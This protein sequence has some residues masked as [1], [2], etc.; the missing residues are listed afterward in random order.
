MRGL[1]VTKKR[2]AICLMSS[3]SF[4]LICHGF[5]M[6]NPSYSHDS[7]TDFVR[8]YDN[9]QVGL[10]RFGQ[11]AWRNLFGRVTATWWIG[12]V[13]A[14]CFGL[15]A[16]LISEVFNTNKTITNILMT[17][18]LVTN[19][20]FSNSVATYM[21][22]VDIYGGALLFSVISVYFAVRYKY[23]FLL[24]FPFVSL[25]LSLYQPYALCVPS[26]LI[27]FVLTRANE[28]KNAIRLLTKSA[29]MLILGY[30]TYRFVLQLYLD[31]T[32]LNLSVGYNSISNIG[33]PMSIL[34]QPWNEIA[35][36]YETG[37][38]FA[39]ATFKDMP[40]F[41]LWIAIFAISFVTEAA[42]YQ[43][44]ILH[45]SNYGKTAFYIL[46][47]LTPL[48]FNFQYIVSKAV[49]HVLMVYSVYFIWLLPL[50]FFDKT[51][52]NVTSYNYGNNKYIRLLYKGLRFLTP[53]V[54]VIYIFANTRYANN[55]YTGK[56]LRERSTLSVM[57]RIMSRAE[58]TQ[59]YDPEKMPI[60]LVGNLENNP[61]IGESDDAYYG[62]IV[63]DPSRFISI[64]N[65]YNAYLHYYMGY[66]YSSLRSSEI[67]Q[68]NEEVESMPAYPNEG[69]TKVID[70]KLVIK[71]AQN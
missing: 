66:T 59:G 45:L 63:G 7:L 33:I 35:G 64:T 69:F 58:A 42:V 27:C 51:Y 9:F 31:K 47:F 5:M 11:G 61:I 6:M 34:S 23:G 10:G 43:R 71:I 55:I 48:F 13:A 30:V 26:L 1:P 8:I 25:S 20:T 21:P 19:Y 60:V 46:L 22:W 12:I 3:F 39:F 32:G 16:F 54:I 29:L 15:A 36:V 24:G 56:Y 65:D 62:P 2:L 68:G 17:G 38:Q 41:A 49:Y 28:T 67:V 70:G 18:I 50:L 37:Y 52:Q 14:I 44:Q 40:F 53:V 57:T 4:V